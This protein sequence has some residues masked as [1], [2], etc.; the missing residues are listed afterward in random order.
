MN[1]QDLSKDLQLAIEK[2]LEDENVV[3]S[4]EKMLSDLI[5]SETFAE[6]IVENDLVTGEVP[7][8]GWK[9][10]AAVKEEEA[11][12][13]V[14]LGNIVSEGVRN[15]EKIAADRENAENMGDE[16]DAENTENVEEA[17]DGSMIRSSE[18][19]KKARKARQATSGIRELREDISGWFYTFMCMNIPVIGWIYLLRLAFGRKHPEKRSFARAYL[20]YKLVFFIVGFL[21]VAI[22]VYEAL[23]VLDELL[24]Y[25]EM[26]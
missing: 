22:V 5:S 10:T 20:I 13:T 24:K 6:E 17:E 8:T 14:F 9:T 7:I 4:N 21:I 2:V 12:D 25:M 19:D 26:L 23:D 16:A 1:E 15:A 18:D 11:G 3:Q